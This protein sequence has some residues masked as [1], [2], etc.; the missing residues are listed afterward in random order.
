MPDHVN[1]KAIDPF[2]QPEAHHIMHCLNHSGI[3]PV[4]VG[5][6]GKEGVIVI[7]FGSGIELPSVSA[8]FR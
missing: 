6:L 8:E 5:L 2:P 4:Q 7:L 1:T 3:A